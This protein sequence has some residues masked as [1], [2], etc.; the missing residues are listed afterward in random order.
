MKT[1][2]DPED[3]LIKLRSHLERTAN[4]EASRLVGE[5][6]VLGVGVTGSL[7]TG[8]VWEGSDIDLV[9]VRRDWDAATPDYHC[10]LINGVIV[11]STIL[12][13]RDLERHDPKA[14]RWLRG[15]KILDDEYK[16]IENSLQYIPEI[17]AAVR[18][19]SIDKALETLLR[20]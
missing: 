5:T 12:T 1:E 9:V 16:I 4:K 6:E 15:I 7:A 17:D 14:L 3:D 19:T 11:H 10:R 8:S 13:K 2:R 20:G 18:K